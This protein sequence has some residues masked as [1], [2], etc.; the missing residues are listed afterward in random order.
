[1]ERLHF[2]ETEKQAF[3][4]AFAPT[5]TDN[6]WNLFINEC[7][8]RALIPGT[9]VIFSIRGK[10]EWDPTLGKKVPVTSVV[11]MTTIAALRLIAARSGNYEGHK[12][13]TYVYTR[14]SEDQGFL[15]SKVPLGRVPHA[16]TV[17]MKRRGWAD[18]IFAV[19]RYDACVQLKGDD[20]IPT[21][22][23]EKRGE[24]QLAKCC[25]AAGLREL[26]PE[27][28]AGLYIEEEMPRLERDEEHGTPVAPVAL[29]KATIVPTA[30]PARAEVESAPVAA[31]T[32]VTGN[33]ASRD[34]QVEN[35]SPTLQPGAPDRAM[36]EMDKLSAEVN[37]Q[38]HNEQTLAAPPKPAPAAPPMAGLFGDDS[39][40]AAP[41]PI[42]AA[43]KAVPQPQNQPTTAP[44]AALAPVAPPVSV[45]VQVSSAV[46]P[47]V[48][49]A[50]D[51][52][53]TPPAA[54]PLVP[55]PVPAG[56]TPAT[57]AEHAQFMARA[58]KIVRD[59]L[60]KAGVKDFECGPLVSGWLTKQSGK[61]KVNRISAAK[62][63]E[64]LGKLEAVAATPEAVV[65]ILKG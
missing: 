7:E 40:A 30:N 19:A 35:S 42:Q 65:T 64:L 49:D 28:C 27:D 29:P 5:A 38:T 23:W 22:M 39:P 9:H 45:P 8:R 62:F 26:A 1:M 25:E 24:E 53:F 33:P 13:F 14:E 60:P 12:P 43:P 55:M 50:P 2:S 6:Q 15:E 61:I 37:R 63:E 31:A 44:Q 59:V 32:I 10:N 3:R 16:V 11:F 4:A 47:Q 18:P 57:A 51:A 48:N 36:A 54:P 56:D 17:E 21:Q 41:A 52:M 20:K 46:P 58:A 34:V